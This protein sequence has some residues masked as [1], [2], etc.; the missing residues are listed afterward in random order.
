MAQ[1]I[2]YVDISTVREGKLEE[3]RGA[4]GHLAGFVEENV[5]Q[6]I[7][8]GFYLDEGRSQ[9]TVVAVHPDSESLAFHL[10]TGAAEF[11]KFA[12]LIELSRIDVYGAVDEAVCE[13]LHQKARA[14]GSGTVAVHELQAGF[15]R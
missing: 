14:L 6:L 12:H 10:D 15:A 3:L 7:S 11:R 2:V 1:P 9:M 5:P 13:R 8:Y 4:M